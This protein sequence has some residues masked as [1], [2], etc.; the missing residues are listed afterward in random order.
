VIRSICLFILISV[1]ITAC[2]GVTELPTVTMTPFPTY[3][4][5]CPTCSPTPI[6][7]T[8]TPLPF[9]TTTPVIII[10]DPNIDSTPT[11]T[12]LSL[13]LSKEHIAILRPA[14]ASNV[15]SPFRINGYAGPSWNNRVELRLIGEDG[16][17]ISRKIAYLLSLPGYSGPFTAEMD[18]ETTL[19]AEAARLEVST[20]S[21]RD[22][23]LDHIASVDLILLSIG[24]P[25][26]HWTI[27]GPEQITILSPREYEMIRGGK[28]LVKGVGWVNQEGPLHI[29]VLDREGNVVGTTQV[30]INSSGPGV[31]GTFEGEIVYEIDETQLGRIAVY[32]ASQTIPGI[33]HYTSLIINLM[34]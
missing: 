14:A 28:V 19:I 34:P 31:T 32:E 17:L 8:T 20:F 6:S 24:A 11:P 12:P 2:T 1:I 15:T 7:E 23:K 26:V 22:T 3:P 33:I 30:Q 25:L 16:R 27:H 29:D 21:V 9:T 13:S 10:E 18:F 5:P 4:S